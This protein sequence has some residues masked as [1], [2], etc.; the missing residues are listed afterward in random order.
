MRK[1]I[2]HVVSTLDRCG[3]VNVMR[4]IVDHL[5]DERFHAVV[6][7]LSAEGANS[8]IDEFLAKGVSVRTLNLSRAGWLA[9]GR[10]PLARLAAEVNADVVHVHGFRATVLAGGI[11]VRSKVVS[12]VHCDLIRDYRL[13]Y[14]WVAGRLMAACEYS[15][16]KRFDGV[17]AVSQSVADAALD[18]G[19]QAR[20]IPNGIDLGLYFP[21]KDAEEIRWLRWRLGWPENRVIVLHTGAL[22]ERKNP[23]GAIAGFRASILGRTGMLAIAGDGPMRAACGEL[24]A[25]A[26]NIVFL[27]KRTDIPDLLRAAD[28][29]LSNSSAE[30][31]PMALLEGCAAGI[32]VVAT[33]IAPHE[34][35]RRMFPDQVTLFSE[36]APTA[37]SEALDKLSA[38]KAGRAIS[39]PEK[40]LE[41][42]S[43]G[44][45]SRHYQGFFDDLLRAPQSMCRGV[46]SRPAPL[47]WSTP[48][49]PRCSTNSSIDR[50]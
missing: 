35:I 37:V 50:L 49:L 6:A 46:L 39:P 24:A 21:A 12:T 14:G 34:D 11:G 31:L 18:S 22:I 26:S 19:I 41:R 5:D 43:A 32:D 1:T 20:M 27:G 4:G 44:A 25:G 2:V 47:P 28:F 15:A 9:C 33:A 48:S 23:L 8:C 42:I 36:G 29:L 16:L 17:A 10:Q 3:P 7:T 13:A 38:A 45:M 40:S 30:G